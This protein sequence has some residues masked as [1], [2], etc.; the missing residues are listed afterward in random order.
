MGIKSYRELR[1]W[2]KGVEL[3]K[4]TYELTEKFPR[5]ELYGLVSQMRRAA[6][7]IPSNIAEGFRR[8]HNK[9]YKQF[10]IYGS[11]KLR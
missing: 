7:S 1:V 6:V 9:E 11:R 2:K 8:Y 10:L 5:Q 4:D 3:V